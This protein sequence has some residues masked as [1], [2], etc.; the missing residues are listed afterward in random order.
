MYVRSSSSQNFGQTASAA[1][2]ATATPS[3]SST[4]LTSTGSSYTSAVTSLQASANNKDWSGLNQQ[5][6]NLLNDPNLTSNAG[7]LIAPLTGLQTKVQIML[8]GSGQDVS[9]DIQTLIQQLAK[10]ANIEAST[11]PDELLINQEL[12]MQRL[13]DLSNELQNFSNTNSGY[14]AIWNRITGQDII[15]FAPITSDLADIAKDISVTPLNASDRATILAQ[16]IQ[17]QQSIQTAWASAD[18]NIF[19]LVGYTL[20]LAGGTAA[21]AAMGSYAGGVAKEH[22]TK[23]AIK[24]AK[25]LHSYV[26]GKKYDASPETLP[27]KPA[28]APKKRKSK[29]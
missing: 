26:T 11:T 24:H 10:Q 13:Y 12:L 21:I 19:E 3:A 20:L 25:R 23:H 18:E 6:T 4:S 2:P 22:A 15:L 9:S 14:K 5:I 16:F 28:E 27:E 17:Q 1:T 29:K 7:T 8:N